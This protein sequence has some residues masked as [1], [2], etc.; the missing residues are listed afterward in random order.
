MAS[1]N[2]LK[3]NLKAAAAA[4]AKSRASKGRKTLS[5]R[6]AALEAKISLANRARVKKNNL[7]GKMRR[8]KK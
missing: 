2:Q 7:K 1:G 6:V 5:Q 4:K 3:K 8:M